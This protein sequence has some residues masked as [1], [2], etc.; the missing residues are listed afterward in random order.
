[1]SPALLEAVRDRHL[2][3]QRQRVADRRVEP[4]R[5]AERRLEVATRRTNST[6]R[7]PRRRKRC[8]AD[9][10]G[11]AA[12]SASRAAARTAG[13]GTRRC[14]GVAPPREGVV[15]VAAQDRHVRAHDVEE[16]RVREAADGERAL[17]G[18]LAPGGAPA[19]RAAPARRARRRRAGRR[20]RP[21]SA[22]RATR[23]CRAAPPRAA[24]HAQP[25]ALDG[26][27]RDRIGSRARASVQLALQPAE[28]QRGSGALLPSTSS[29]S[30]RQASESA[31]DERIVRRSGSD[32]LEVELARPQVASRGDGSWCPAR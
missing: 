3:P 15:G 22:C 13:S 31:L 16:A 4:E 27:D 10:A 21:P 23:R 9:G 14:G 18:R 32:G 8:L 28:V 30:R 11:R 5:R 7:S 1:M 6:R 20:A 24:S 29:R 26:R 17:E 19:Q 2:G 12:A 25:R